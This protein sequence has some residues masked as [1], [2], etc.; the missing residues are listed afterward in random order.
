MKPSGK[1]DS[2]LGH[3]VLVTGVAGFIGGHLA[4]RLRS[5][6]LEVVGIDNFSNGMMENLSDVR[7]YRKFKLVRGDV[8]DPRALSRACKEADSIFHLA[9]NPSVPKSAELPLWDFEQNAVTTLRVLEEA[10]KNDSAVVFASSSTVYG[11]AALPTPEDHPLMPISNY[12]SS[13]VTG[14]TYCG[15]Y[16]SLYGLETVSSRYYNI[17]GPRTRKGVMFDF[18]KKLQA[19][20]SKLEVLGTGNQEK[21]YVHI[22]DALDGTL[23][24]VAKG[25]MRGERYNVGLGESYTVKQLVA[26]ILRMLE[27]E[28]RTKV[29]YKGGLSWPGDVQRTRPDISKI[30]KLGFSPK[31]GIAEGLRM[32]MGW[33]EKEFGKIVE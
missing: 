33:Y 26:K 17:Y 2:R 15:S 28:G 4:G 10:R 8:L 31:I 25:A 1:L 13:K 20:S 22:D 3:K 16:S 18:F 27:L 11:E 24:A 9:A 5:M 23:L 32:A 14:E 6:G 29:F 21:D 7:G 30:K 12:G 19:D